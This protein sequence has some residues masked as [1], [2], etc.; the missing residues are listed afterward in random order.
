MYGF[1]FTC[2]ATFTKPPIELH[3]ADCS[4]LAN[5]YQVWTSTFL[6]SDFDGRSQCC[7]AQN[8]TVFQE[9]TQTFS[10]GLHE[11]FHKRDTMEYRCKTTNWYLHVQTQS[12]SCLEPEISNHPFQ[13]WG[14]QQQLQ[15]YKDLYTCRTAKSCKKP[16]TWLLSSNTFNPTLLIWLYSSGV[17]YNT[18]AWMYDHQLDCSCFLKKKKLDCSSEFQNPT[19]FKSKKNSSGLGKERHL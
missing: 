11:Q 12:H 9:W 7:R 4:V 19:V 2:P 5:G 8:S 14:H 3:E 15:F 17:Q 1:T 10:Q 13:W 16:T 6:N 18:K